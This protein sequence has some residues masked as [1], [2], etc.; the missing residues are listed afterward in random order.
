MNPKKGTKKKIKNSRTPTY[1]IGVLNAISH[2]TSRSGAVCPFGPMS[3]SCQRVSR[4]TSKVGNPCSGRSRNCRN[5]PSG[6]ANPS[7]TASANTGTVNREFP[8][9][10]RSSF[11]TSSRPNCISRTFNCLV[12]TCDSGR[13]TARPTSVPLAR[14][15]IHQQPSHS[16]RSLHIPKPTS[17]KS[18]VASSRDHVVWGTRRRVHTAPAPPIQERPA[19]VKTNGVFGGRLDIT[20]RRVILPLASLP[21]RDVHEAL[22]SV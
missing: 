17:S 5:T 6:L 16:F 14:I 3:G 2:S 10:F 21:D 4:C 13:T 19:A 9:S 8:R 15:R 11:R 12:S 1:G 22:I 20:E 7:S 18:T